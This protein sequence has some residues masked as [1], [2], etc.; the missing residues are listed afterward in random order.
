[1][2]F[3]RLSQSLFVLFVILLFNSASMGQD[4]I[5]QQFDDFYQNK[6]NSWQEYRMIKKPFLQEF[7]STIV[8]SIR[9]RDQKIVDA[10]AEISRFSGKISDLNKQLEDTNL[11]LIESSSLN[12]TIGFM[13]MQLTKTSYI[14]TVW[15]IMAALVTVAIL[16]Y[17]LYLRN[18]HV[19][20]EAKQLLAGVEAEYIAYKDSSREKHSKLKR[21]LQTAL[22][23]L[24]ENRIK[25]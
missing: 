7:L 22:N 8:D 12:E 19:T 2:Q 1:M 16:L 13:G 10:R 3:Q 20:T 18:S 6:T 11:A 5:Q 9:V 14:V 21:E 17:L 25:I 15:V 24:H 4:S 23:A